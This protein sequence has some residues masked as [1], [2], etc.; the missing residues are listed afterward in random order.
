MSGEAQNARMRGTNRNQFCKTTSHTHEKLP[1]VGERKRKYFRRELGPLAAQATDRE[2]DI[3]MAS[4]CV[5][6]RPDHFLDDG[7]AQKGTEELTPE[8]RKFAVVES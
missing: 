8:L 4:P 7:P 6:D 1:F 5:T 3:S 2:I